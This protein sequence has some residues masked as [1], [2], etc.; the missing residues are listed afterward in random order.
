[1]TEIPRTKNGAIID[2]ND[3]IVTYE[4]F[5]GLR[6]TVASDRIK[7][8]ELVTATNVD[9]D[10]SGVISRRAG[11]TL[12]NASAA[13]SLWSN[14]TVTLFVSGTSMYRLNADFTATSIA[15]G[16][17]QGLTMRYTEVNGVVYFGNGAETGAYQNG[18]VR[19]WGL[20]APAV[21][22]QVSAIPGMLPAG[23][24]QYAITY[25]ASDGRESGTWNAGQITLAA[26]QGLRL[27][28]IPVSTDRTVS[29]VRL[30]LTPQNGDVLF[31]AA[32]IPNGT[33][34]Y[35]YV[36]TVLALGVQLRTQFLDKPTTMQE[37]ALYHGRIYGFQFEQLKYT[38]QF[39]YEL[40]DANNFYLLESAGKIIAPVDSGIF[41]AT[42]A[43]TWFYQ[44]NGPEDFIRRNVA[45]YGAI[46][47][48]LSYI[49]HEKYG[50]VPMWQST[51]GI[52]L[53]T[54]AGQLE[55]ITRKSYVYASAPTGASLFK[56]TSGRNQYISVLQG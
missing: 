13:H 21:Q 34:S 14:S 33:T 43:N 20:R 4:G 6:N 29:S 32:K 28:S 3:P 38:E 50:I 48:T 55:N 35:D 52:V 46:F 25:E 42:E 11:A 51:Q 1:M 24:Y 7:D 10:S 26:D 18:A 22:P 53:G 8:T 45:G 37:V 12:K 44:G 56:Q 23:T 2:T 9:I 39:N 40:M 5:T 41:V 16:L 31:L 15:T 27:T 54:D 30:Y 49:E 47:G 19:S 36:A 17:S